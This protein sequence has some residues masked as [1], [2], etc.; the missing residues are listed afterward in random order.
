MK[1]KINLIS[2]FCTILLFSA[3]DDVFKL[4]TDGRLSYED[5]FTDNSLTSGYLNKCYAYIPLTGMSYD[6]NNFLAVYG[7][8]A[9]DAEDIQNGRSANYYSGMSTSSS[10]LVESGSNGSAYNNMYTGVRKCNVFIDNIDNAKNI[11][12]ESNRNKWKGEAYTLRAFYFWY[13]VKRMGPLPIIKHELPLD[14]DYSTHIRP[15]FYEC[16]KSIIEDCDSALKQPDFPWRTNLENDRGSMNK[17]VAVAIKSQA[18]LFVASPLWNGGNNYWKETAEVTKIALDSLLTKNYALHNPKAASPTVKAYSDYQRFFLLKP[19]MLDNP[20]NDKET[21]Y[22]QKA[23]I[24]AVW[25]QH[26][27][28]TVTDVTKAGACPSQELVDAYETLNGMPVLNPAQPYLDADHLQPNYNA[29]NTQYNKLKPY[30]NRD[31]RLFSTIY[32]NGVNLNLTTNTLPVWT[33][34]GGTAGISKTDRKFTRTGYYLRKFAD[35]T[36][37]KTANKDGYWRYFRLAEMY[38]NYAEAEFYANG[39]TANAVNAL[40]QTRLR[41]GLPAL[42]ATISATEFEQRLR[43]ERRIEFA[44]E[45]QRYF[46]VR[47]WKVQAENEGIITGMNIK[48]VSPGVFNFERI[49]VSR[50]NVTDEKY[51]IWPIP[52]N[53]QLKYKQVGVDYQNQGW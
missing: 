13:M 17:S 33:Y 25:Q 46:D 47:R 37:T 49:V 53:E 44:F 39:V 23:Q 19:E 29:A 31:P 1:K 10:N 15:T 36:S 28:P 6:S 41:A 35:Y 5:I 8:E 48:A 12:I 18:M 9:Q 3:C 50:R 11:N 4:P 14:F 42:A 30:E 24:G 45:E 52:Y 34:V 21:I 40:N 26:G 16:V 32:C 51:L 27:L 43:N 22:S 7:D 2:V 20:A 38:L